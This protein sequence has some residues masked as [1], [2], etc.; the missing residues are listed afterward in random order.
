[1]HSVVVNFR[2]LVYCPV[3]FISVFAGSASIVMGLSPWP[4]PCSSRLV[5]TFL[6]ASDL[7]TLPT[8][9]I[10][11]RFFSSLLF[12]IF[13]CTLYTR[14]ALL[15]SHFFSLLFIA[16]SL[17]KCWPHIQALCSASARLTSNW[18]DTSY[19]HFFMS[20]SW[21]YLLISNKTW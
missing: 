3:V 9:A 17:C 10:C 1:M 21:P 11:F 18:P 12:S 15:L 14:F 19:I 7:N 20:D 5:Q 2:A 13:L 16:P 6:L 4:S 8:S